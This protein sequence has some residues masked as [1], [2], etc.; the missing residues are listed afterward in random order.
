MLQAGERLWF[1]DLEGKE[2]V[3]RRDGKVGSCPDSDTGLEAFQRVRLDPENDGEIT[4]VFQG[5]K[6]NDPI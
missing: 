2:L 4:R 6:G 3:A 1:R 5:G